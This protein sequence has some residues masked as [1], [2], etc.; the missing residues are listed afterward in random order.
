MAITSNTPDI[1]PLTQS[2]Q[3]GDLLALWMYISILISNFKVET[4]K[5]RQR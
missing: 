3:L 4:A 5:E 1:V 2:S